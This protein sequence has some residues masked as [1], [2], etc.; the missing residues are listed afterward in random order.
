[1][2]KLAN[3]GLSLLLCAAS[4][5]GIAQTNSDWRTPAE[6]GDYRTTPDYADTMAYLE[7]IA[8]AAPRQV[9]I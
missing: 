6:I 3:L 1:M 4:C 8:A 9:R 2:L 5:S 7:R